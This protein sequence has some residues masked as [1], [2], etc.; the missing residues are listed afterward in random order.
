MTW[1]V[2]IFGILSILLLIFYSYKWVDKRGF[3]R[4]HQVGTIEANKK[5]NK[6]M[7]KIYKRALSLNVNPNNLFKLSDDKTEFGD[8]P[9]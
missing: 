6:E 5:C 7:A 9:T 8:K 3:K 2:T 4:G 1:A